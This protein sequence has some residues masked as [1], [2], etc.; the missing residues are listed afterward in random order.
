MKALGLN[1]ELTVH[2]ADSALAAARFDDASLDAVFID[3]D[4]SEEA[5]TRDIAA[6]LP[7]VKRGGVIAGHDV[8]QFGVAKA[9]SKILPTATVVG[10]CW[11]QEVV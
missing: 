5:V 3:A 1:G 8:D 11:V 7:K 10:R 2:P 4:H 6:W 9:V